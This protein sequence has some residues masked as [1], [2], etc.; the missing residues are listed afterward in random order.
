M[1]RFFSIISLC[2]MA[3]VAFVS[4][5]DTDDINTGKATVAFDQAEYSIKENKGIFNIPV[6]VNGEQNGPIRVSIEVS[7]NGENCKE[8]V[9]YMI[10]SKEVIIPAKKKQVNVEIKAI[11][12]R[13]IND[14]R[15]FSM[16]IASASGASVSETNA[17]TNVTLKDND[18]IPYERMAGVW[19][20]TAI[21]RATDSHV[22]EP[23]SWDMKLDIVDDDDPSYGSLIISSPWAVWDGT[24]PAFDEDGNTLTHQMTFHHNASTGKTTVDMKMG[25]IMFDKLNF[26]T[27]Q[28]VDFSNATIY[29]ATEGI[30]GSAVRSGTITGVVNENFDEIKFSSP[31]LILVYP[32]T[33]TMSYLLYGNFADI[34]LKL[35]K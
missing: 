32:E 22:D 18:D 34:T 26:G 7:S 29:S 3:S 12:D 8:D 15:H 13:I 11:D 24:T 16:R 6:V 23:I 20:V 33:S 10:T 2:L 21:N 14:D 1:K 5:H 17:T 30:N 35:K 28:D 31:L 27:I 25:S 19:T 9:N 4:C